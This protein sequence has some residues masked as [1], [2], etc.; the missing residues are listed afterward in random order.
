MTGCASA[1][2]S[3]RIS[4]RRS[5]NGERGSPPLRL[6]IG[7]LIWPQT[8]IARGGDM[9]SFRILAVGGAPAVGAGTPIAAVAQDKDKAIADRQD[10]M[11]KQIREWIVVR[12]YI[13]G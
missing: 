4:E 11:K 9:K 5:R 12:N 13:Q 1:P 3:R 8:G 10:F 2:G 7:C 6:R